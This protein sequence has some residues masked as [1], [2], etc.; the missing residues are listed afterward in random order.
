MEKNKDKN[1]GKKQVKVPDSVSET[2]LKTTGGVPADSSKEDAPDNQPD[3]KMRIAIVLL[4]IAVLGCAVYFGLPLLK[5]PAAPSPVTGTSNVT[6]YFF[7]G[8]ECPHCHN[9]MPYVESIRQKY[10]EVDFRILEVWHNDTNNALLSLMNHNLGR[11]EGGVP[12]IIIGNVSLLGEDEINK[13]LEPTILL[14]KGNQTASSL[15]E[16][17]PVSGSP[18]GTNGSPARASLPAGTSV[19]P[20]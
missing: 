15:R 13:D 3:T 18:A 9:V 5:A 10:P 17:V 2:S 16:A 1:S 14:Q 7:Y 6:V 12:E 8:T 19:P 4:A 20:Q 11:Q